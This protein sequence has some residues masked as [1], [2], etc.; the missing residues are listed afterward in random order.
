MLERIS[1]HA[2]SVLLVF[3][4]LENLK[5]QLQD[6]VKEAITVLLG[7]ALQIQRHLCALQD[8][9]ALRVQIPEP[10]LARLIKFPVIP[11]TIKAL[12]AKLLAYFQEM[13]II[14]IIAKIRKKI[15]F[16]DTIV[17]LEI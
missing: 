17:I 8:I 9:T 7:V 3:T 13:D 1:T 10:F 15:A 14:S 16:Q 12:L 11:A 5:S 6:H 4:V 2:L